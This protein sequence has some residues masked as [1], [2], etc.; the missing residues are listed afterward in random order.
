MYDSKSP[1]NDTRYRIR[2]KAHNL[3]QDNYQNDPI[4]R[5][6]KGISFHVFEDD[7]RCSRCKFSL[8]SQQNLT[9]NHFVDMEKSLEVIGSKRFKDGGV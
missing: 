7:R 3:T 6:I 2:R 5:R 1:F 4:D 8:F 9:S